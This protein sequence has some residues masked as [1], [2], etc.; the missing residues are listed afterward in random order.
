MQYMKTIK[1]KTAFYATF[2]TGI[3]LVFI[4]VRFLL[5]PLGAETGFGI[6]V[7]VNGNFSFHYIKGIRDLFSG[8]II[9]LLLFVREFRALGVLLLAATIIPAVDFFIV[10]NTPDHVG[11]N[12][13]PHLTAVVLAVVL[14]VYYTFSPSKNQH[15]AAV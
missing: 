8:I 6:H 1:Q 15:Y 10:W 4:G 5:N 3:L 7:P 2:L 11:A 12:L 13:Y 9:L 14:G